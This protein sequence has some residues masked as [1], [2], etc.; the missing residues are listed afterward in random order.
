[1]S[2][3]Q[4]ITVP[5][6]TIADGSATA[7]SDPVTGDL[8]QCRYMKDATTPFDNGVG[9]T[10]TNETTGETL[11]AEAAVNA[12]ATRAPRQATHSTAG[13]ALGATITDKIALAGDRI[14]IVIASGGNVKTGSFVFLLT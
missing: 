12:S 8:S 2:Y 5:V 10:I 3:V 11:W 13:V 1:M 9:F 6:T 7:Y 14:K 4:R